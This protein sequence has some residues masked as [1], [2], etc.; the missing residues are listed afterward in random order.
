MHRR[1]PGRSAHTVCQMM[2]VCLNSDSNAFFLFTV[3]WFLIWTLQFCHQMWLNKTHCLSPNTTC[4]LFADFK[5]NSIVSNTSVCSDRLLQNNVA[6]H[7]QYKTTT[8]ATLWKLTNSY[9]DTETMFSSYVIASY[10]YSWAFNMEAE[11]LA[12]DY[13]PA[14][15]SWSARL[16]STLLHTEFLFWQSAEWK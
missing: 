5:L 11:L 3:L 15:K 12:T 16:Q 2:A 7:V 10:H 6:T 4:E 8:R 14:N 1:C 13:S 9:G